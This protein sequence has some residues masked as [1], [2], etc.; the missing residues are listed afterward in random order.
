MIIYLI[1]IRNCSLYGL[2]KRNLF[3]EKCCPQ[4]CFCCWD[5]LCY[6]LA[7]FLSRFVEALRVCRFEHLMGEQWTFLCLVPSLCL[8]LSDLTSPSFIIYSH[9]PVSQQLKTRQ[10]SL[11]NQSW[12]SEK[13]MTQLLLNAKLRNHFLQYLSVRSSW[14][15]LCFSSAG[16]L[17]KG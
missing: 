6:N 5:I 2:D 17:S 7:S 12:H 8:S 14:K 10:F 9:S 15:E 3:K 11:E 4:S 16:H 13:L 1:S